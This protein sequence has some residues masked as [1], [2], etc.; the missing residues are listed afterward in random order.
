MMRTIL[1]IAALSLIFSS[2]YKPE[3]NIVNYEDSHSKVIYDLPGDTLASDGWE[4]SYEAGDTYMR[5][6]F[7]NSSWSDSIRI[8]PWAGEK[9][10]AAAGVDDNKEEGITWLPAS[11]AHP[12]AP[13]ENNAYTS[14]ADGKDYIYRSGAWYQMS[15]DKYVPAN[16]SISVNW[17]GSATVPPV[18]AEQNWAY[19]DNNNRRV[20]VYS[21]KAWALM[22][23]DANYRSNVKFVQVQYSKSGKETGK[24]N[25][26]LFSF[27]TG[28]Q[29]YI[30]DAADSARYLK[31]DQWDIAFTDNFNSLIWVNNAGYKQNPGYGSPM[32]RTSVLMYNYG[33]EFMNEAPADSLFDA[34]PL[35]NMQ[36]GFVSEFGPGINA[37]Y[38]YSTTTHVAQPYPYRAFYLRLQQLDPVTGKSVVKYGKLQLISMYKGAPEVVTDLNWPSPYFTFR[39][40]IQE[41]GSHNLKTKD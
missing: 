26:F 28:K 37:W 17:R 27:R 4:S 10:N 31:T 24:Y 15:I 13:H 39:Y 21:G 22:V 32:T 23:N 1:Y 41:D 18:N 29:I 34:L 11:A 9:I 38:E 40:F 5:Q 6:Q 7:Y 12:V 16:D 14:S 3:E 8:V 20:Y 2:C 30:R 35:S 25:M 19:Y 33:Y 36:M